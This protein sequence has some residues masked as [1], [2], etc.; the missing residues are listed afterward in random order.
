MVIASNGKSTRVGNGPNSVGGSGSKLGRE[1]LVVSQSIGKVLV[2]ESNS[3]STGSSGLEVSGSIESFSNKGEFSGRKV[4]LVASVREDR[5]SSK[6]GIVSN[7]KGKGENLVGS[8]GTTRVDLNSN[9]VSTIRNEVVLN[10]KSTFDISTRGNDGVV[11]EGDGIEVVETNISKGSED[12]ISGDLS[13]DSGT[14]V[15]E[16]NTTQISGSSRIGWGND[17]GNE[18]D[19]GID[20]H[21]GTSGVSFSVEDIQRGNRSI[22]KS[23]GTGN[24]D[25]R[26]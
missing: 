10:G 18:N 13:N 24:I 6:S 4:S 15:G 9:R 5:S 14:V 21:I 17:G 8:R 20:L 19:G 11:V 7:N 23:S 3:G 12:G 2:E 1:Q 22:N 25:Q 16:G 26:N